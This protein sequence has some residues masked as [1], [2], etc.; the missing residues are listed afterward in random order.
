MATI[1]EFETL[2]RE[3][4]FSPAEPH[5]EFPGVFERTK[6][7]TVEIDIHGR[8]FKALDFIESFGGYRHVVGYEVPGPF[9]LGGIHRYAPMREARIV[10]KRFSPL[11]RAANAEAEEEELSLASL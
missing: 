4:Y 8:R 1:E 2:A 6:G 9:G 11:H 7:T 10:G 5:G 3:G